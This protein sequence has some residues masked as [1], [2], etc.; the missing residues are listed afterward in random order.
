[1]RRNRKRRWSAIAVVLLV[2]SGALVPASSA[3]NSIQAGCRRTTTGYRC[4]YGPIDLSSGPAQFGDFV[5]APLEPGFI[6]SA[7][8]VV[9]DEEGERVPS[10]SVH[11]HHSGWL[12][13]TRS[14]FG[15]GN[16]FEAI[17]GTGKEATRMHLPEGYGYFWD[18]TASTFE[19]NSAWQLYSEVHPMHDG[20]PAVVYIRL[21]L[22][23]VPSSESPEISDVRTIWWGVLG[24]V[25]TQEFDVEKGSGHHGRFKLSREFVMPFTGRFIWM[26]G[27]LHDGAIKL[28]LRNI[29]KEAMVYSSRAVYSKN[30]KWDLRTTTVLS[31]GVGIPAD[32]GDVLRLTAVYD[33]THRWEKVMGIMRAVVVP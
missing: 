15:C 16:P 9:V 3:N 8:A 1:M 12:N 20:A 13:P 5:A 27:H 29:T 17:Y 10:H 32:Q 21:N 2:S 28:K 26:A 18:Q 4:L 31:D 22:G 11:L 7:R 30:S 25:G 19:P 14:D 33:S 23:F 24:C 6:T